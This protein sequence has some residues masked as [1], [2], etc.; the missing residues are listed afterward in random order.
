MDVRHWLQEAMA[1]CW[2]EPGAKALCR[3]EATAI[4]IEMQDDERQCFTNTAGL[5]LGGYVNFA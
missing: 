5:A 4:P 3:D 1:A 2:L